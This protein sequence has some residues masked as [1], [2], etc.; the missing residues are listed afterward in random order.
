MKHLDLL[1][2]KNSKDI[3][4]YGKKYVKFQSRQRKK[5]WR[6]SW[7]CDIFSG[8]DI[9]ILLCCLNYVNS[10]N[11][12][13][14]ISIEFNSIE[15]ADKLV[16]ILLECICYYIINNTNHKILFSFR[17]RQ[18][19]WTE[20]IKYTSIN[21]IT[22]G[23]STALINNHFLR[24]FSLQHFRQVIF[25]D[26]I[27]TDFLNRLFT[28]VFFFFKHLEIED[29]TNEMLC[30]SISELVGN[31]IEHGHS[32]CLLDID[33]TDNNYQKRND[34]EDHYYYGINVVI[35]NFSKTSFNSKIRSK[36]SKD[37]EFDNR[38]MVVK[39][40]EKYHSQH[41]STNYTEDDFYS[42]ASFQ[43]KISGSLKKDVAGG[44]GL[45]QLI[46]SL[47]EKSDVHL[48]YMLSKKRALFFLK[49]FLQYDDNQNIG[50]NKENNFS[51][52]I[53]D[54]SVFRHC[55]TFFPGTAYNLNFAIRKGDLDNGE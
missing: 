16:Y 15:F 6:I 48:C 8:D 24:D 36:L 26:S 37:I 53:P 41:F 38:Y 29:S 35:L 30:E 21:L 31:A 33:V 54:E 39:N 17:H 5:Y 11:K 46:K 19:I 2:L 7:K 52:H 12:S 27:K 50:F 25:N 18:T 45:T 23:Y 47:E 32:D 51:H 49:E 4:K 10:K 14:P 3:M 28:E 43:H 9:Y 13:F 20:G 42:V 40:A 55:S 34:V 1:F 22:S 44:V